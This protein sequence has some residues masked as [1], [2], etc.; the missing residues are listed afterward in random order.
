MAPETKVGLVV[1]LGFIICFAVILANRGQKEPIATYLTDFGESNRSTTS[2]GRNASPTSGDDALF[3]Q[4][5]SMSFTGSRP[6]RILPMRVDQGGFSG[7][8]QSAIDPTSSRSD[9]S[10][11]ARQ[12]NDL[13]N[14]AAGQD[15]QS[16]NSSA[17]TSQPHSVN[18]Q[19]DG[20]MIGSASDSPSIATTT[21][22]I[23]TRRMDAVAP[24]N[25]GTSTSQTRHKVSAGETLSKIAA[26]Y[27]G[28]SSNAA[29]HAIFEANRH[30]L[31]NP[32]VLRV[33]VEL[34]IPDVDRSAIALPDPTP[35]TRSPASAS[36]KKRTEGDRG[37]RWYQIKKQDR[38]IS[39][40]RRELGDASR[41]YEI[42]E[43]N[44]ERFPDP[45]RI[46]E[47]VRI[48]LPQSAFVSQGGV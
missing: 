25:V 14:N 39:I 20:Q 18:P 43:L 2:S 37:F 3:L 9:P 13:R 21:Q 45:S 6:Q 34:L 44:K 15:D 22:R 47:G 1:G 5:A 7:P 41:W 4:E 27:F 19:L 28:R 29:V 12:I 46:R 10:D 33:G 16:T 8:G 11:A 35:K 40:A 17:L 23:D 36:P 26:R 30:V 32:N 24:L 31:Q 48:K 42:H 38:Y